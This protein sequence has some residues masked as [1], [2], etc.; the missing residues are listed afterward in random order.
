MFPGMITLMIH[1]IF[2]I[3]SMGMISEK[4]PSLVKP[5][6]WDVSKRPPQW[7][8]NTR[9]SENFIDDFPPKKTIHLD[10]QLPCFNIIHSHQ[11]TIYR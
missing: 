11:F 2:L 8:L 1:H 3:Y 6:R 10:F 4:A 5:G 7:I 9:C